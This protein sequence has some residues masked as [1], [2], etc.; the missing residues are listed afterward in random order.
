MPRPFYGFLLL[1]Q[2]PGTPTIKSR[3]KGGDEL[4]CYAWMSFGDNL[5]DLG[6]RLSR[7]I[8]TVLLRCT[9]VSIFKA[10]KEKPSGG[11]FGRVTFS[12]ESFRNDNSSDALQKANRRTHNRYNN[13][14][15]R[16]SPNPI[17][18]SPIS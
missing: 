4:I 5:R 3:Q 16:S 14:D 7:I 17:A 9:K 12:D 10:Q 8:K 2:T 1:P 11:L 18:P 15:S 13:L 6:I